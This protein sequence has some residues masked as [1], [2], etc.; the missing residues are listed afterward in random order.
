[1]ALHEA[2]QVEDYDAG[3]FT[4]TATVALDQAQARR[5]KED[6][7]NKAARDAGQNPERSRLWVTWTEAEGPPTV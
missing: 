1:M 5:H 2:D 7:Q 4:C 6:E 3:F